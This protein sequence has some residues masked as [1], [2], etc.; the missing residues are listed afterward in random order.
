M[1]TEGIGQIYGAVVKGHKPFAIAQNVVTPGERE[2]CGPVA[3]N[4]SL[5]APDFARMS[6]TQGEG[7][8][9]RRLD[10]RAMGHDVRAFEETDP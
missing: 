3:T 5:G 10:F 8:D 9:T 1:G 4:P 7:R 2:A 6:G